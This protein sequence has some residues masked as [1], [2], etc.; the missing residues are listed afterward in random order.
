MIEIFRDTNY[1]FLSKKWICIGASC[2]LLLLGVASIA[3]RAL[4]GNPNT[5]PF[6]MGVDFS[7]GTIV[8]VKFKQKT[9]PGVIREAIVKQ[10]VDGEKITIQPVGDEIGQAPKNEVLIRLPNKPQGEQA[11]AGAD[12]ES[13]TDYGGKIIRKAL[14]S[15]NDPAL[16][17]SKTDLNTVGR[18]DLKSRLMELDPLKLS[19]GGQAADQR[20]GEIAGR[21]IDYREKDRGGLIGSVDEIKNLS[22]IEPQLGQSLEQNFYA[23]VAAVRKTD[24]RSTRPSSPVREYWSS[25]LSVSS[26]GAMASEA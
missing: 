15:L 3:W 19:A 14:E 18:I 25:S 13:D 22:G 6:N 17:Q 4:D 2:V 12:A 16:A 9:D 7:G 5:H 21:I 10:K 26:P 1:D 8:N 11:P 23:G 20:Y 24:A